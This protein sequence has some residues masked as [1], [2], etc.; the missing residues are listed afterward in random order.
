MTTMMGRFR[1]EVASQIGKSQSDLDWEQDRYSSG[2]LQLADRRPA[3]RVGGVFALES[4]ARNAKT[5]YAELVYENLVM[6][7]VNAS[8]PEPDEE[9]DIEEIEFSNDPSRGPYSLLDAARLETQPVPQISPGTDILAIVKVLSRN[10][11]LFDHHVHYL[12]KD[13]RKQHQI[14]PKSGLHLVDVNLTNAWL[15]GIDFSGATLSKVN[16]DDAVMTKAN[17][18][19]SVLLDC[20][21]NRAKM[22]LSSFFSA[23]ITGCR[24]YYT[25]LSYTSI[26]LTKIRRTT[27]QGMTL[28]KWTYDHLMDAG[29][30]ATLMNVKREDWD[31]LTDDRTE[32]LVA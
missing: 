10:R 6:A 21:F 11:R 30:G 32:T 1:Q 26:F 23:K 31:F 12:S 18:D 8:K 24:F 17:L 15:A 9:A 19:R 27:F 5:R 16:F 25:D 22:E 20:S 14:W 3:V 2:L 28:D 7:L 29:K 13:N 4:L